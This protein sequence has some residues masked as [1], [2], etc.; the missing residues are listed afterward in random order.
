MSKYLRLN[1]NIKLNYIDVKMSSQQSSLFIEHQ[2]P[3]SF[4]FDN[5]AH[6]DAP[7]KSMAQFLRLRTNESIED[8][9]LSSI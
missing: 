9:P 3:I 2:A 8:R 4:S 5:M 1:F 7:R 6:Q